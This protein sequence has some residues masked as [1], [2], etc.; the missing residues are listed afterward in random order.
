MAREIPVLPDVGSR[1]TLPGRSV[2]STS[3]ASIIRSAIRSVSAPVW[4]CPSTL[5]QSSDAEAPQPTPEQVA[6]WGGL[7]VIAQPYIQYLFAPPEV[8]SGKAEAPPTDVR[9]STLQLMDSVAPNKRLKLT[10]LPSTDRTV[11]LA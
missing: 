11:A 3:A 8:V 5:A 4:F 10:P 9:R 6:Q 1:M 2:P 7:A